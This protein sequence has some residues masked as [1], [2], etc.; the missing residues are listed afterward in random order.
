MRAQ[1]IRASCSNGSP[2][3]KTSQTP[4]QTTPNEARH[5]SS[6]PTRFHLLSGSTRRTLG[7]R[8]FGL[9]HSL[10][11]LR[12]IS[13]LV[14][15]LPFRVTG[16]ALGEAHRWRNRLVAY[17]RAC[18]GTP[19]K[20]ANEGGRFDGRNDAAVPRSAYSVLV[21][22]RHS[23][24]PGTWRHTRHSRSA[25]RRALPLDLH[26]RDHIPFPTSSS[27]VFERR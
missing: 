23:P 10:H 4:S 3:R 26:R 17:F 5:N 27:R 21:R 13:R 25:W 15:R 20:W 12:E 7:Y 8:Q 1:A 2:R 24:S 19:D 9:R 22:F 14:A 16:S 11:H 6:I 18:C